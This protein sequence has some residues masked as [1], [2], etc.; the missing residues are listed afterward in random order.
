MNASL[1]IIISSKHYGVYM[2]F[3]VLAIM[4][5]RQFLLSCAAPFHNN[6]F[7]L[8]FAI[9][10]PVLVYTFCFLAFLIKKF[11]YWLNFMHLLETQIQFLQHSYIHK[12]RCFGIVPLTDFL[13]NVFF[14]MV[15][16]LIVRS[17]SVTT[18][19]FIHF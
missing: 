17:I 4:Q 18:E 3:V 15:Y 7:R 14:K 13:R 8:S 10:E 2:Q 9:P 12:Q 5:R 6:R 11:T 1:R 19:A 16:L